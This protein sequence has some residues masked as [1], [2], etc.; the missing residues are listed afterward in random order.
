[1]IGSGTSQFLPFS[2]FALLQQLSDHAGNDAET[3]EDI[4][5]L[6]R[7]LA[8]CQHQRFRQQ[9]NVLKRN[10]LPFS[11]DRD[12][13]VVID[14]SPEQ[15][16][17]MQGDLLGLLKTLL[18]QAN[19]DRITADD[20]NDIFSATSPYGLQLKVDLSEY[21]QMLLYA[22]GHCTIEKTYRHWKTL[23][24]KKHAVALPIYQRLFLLL[25][26]KPAE[27]RLDEIMQKEGVSRRKAEKELAH[28]RQNLP[29]NISGEHIII[30][31]FKNIPQADLEMLFPNTEIK[32]K[33]FDK[34][35]LGVTAGGGT[36]GSITAT[37]TK[38]AAAANPAAAAA[39]LAGL[40]GVVFR[41]VSKFFGQRTKYMMTL[42]QNLYFH[43]LAN[44]R[45]ALTLL[46]DR[47][48]EEMFKNSALAWFI[49]HRDGAADNTAALRQRVETFVHEAFGMAVSFDVD[50]A[51]GYLRD[52][53]LI[54]HDRLAAVP[55]ATGCRILE[56]EWQASLQQALEE[57]ASSLE[58]IE[59]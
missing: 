34:L 53:G 45:A 26:L 20:L 36:V 41:Q 43:N 21:E 51:I 57:D 48:E 9:L 30:K 29:D 5:Q 37:A 52:I 22:R 28:Y 35:K 14:Y 16:Q 33:P 38:L 42:A 58:D 6:L 3:F 56:T 13:Q 4:R 44:N 18:A 19:Y 39:A 46:V 15:R 40:A 10:F 12:T 23:F 7:Q 55:A 32:L 47:A 8:L 31:L 54:E 49:L 24:L 50:A 1:M 2:R 17:G 11:P 59:A 27:A 25:K